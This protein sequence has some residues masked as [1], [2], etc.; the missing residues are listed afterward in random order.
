VVEETLARLKGKPVIYD[1]V[2]VDEGQDFTGKM[3]AAVRALVNPQTENVTVALDEG[4]NIY[5][6]DLLWGKGAGATPVRVDRLSA[7][8]RNTSE[9]REFASRFSGEPPAAS[10]S[11]LYCETHGPQP[12]FKRVADLDKAAEYVAELIKALHAQGD[13]P[14]SEMAVLY[15]RT[16]SR[17]ERRI[18]IP[19][20]FSRALEAR[21]LISTWMAEDYR[22]KRAYDITTESVTISTIHSAKGLDYACVFLV[23]L[24]E[25]E[26]D[27]WSERQVRNL[28]YVGITRARHRIFIPYVTET[29]IIGELRRCL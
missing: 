25:L 4:Q 21:G 14:L 24:D 8:Y 18:S 5:R 6:G 9:I 26:P 19:E 23:G 15:T 10:G 2:L 20:L 1:A 3:Q 16:I 13:Y 28:V 17:D 27:G 11:T 7:V 12:E 22:S 29:E